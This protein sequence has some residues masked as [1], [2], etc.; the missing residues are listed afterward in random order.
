MTE[1]LVVD[2]GPRQRNIEGYLYL[3]LPPT[4]GALCWHYLGDGLWQIPAILLAFIVMSVV[5][6]AIAVRLG[7]ELVT[8]IER[9]RRML[10]RLGAQSLPSMLFWMFLFYLLLFLGLYAPMIK[11]PLSWEE[12]GVVLGLI[13][14]GAT[15]CTGICGFYMRGQIAASGRDAQ[16]ATS[17]RAPWLWLAKN[18]PFTFIGV[19]GIAIGYVI[20]SRFS[21]T[22]ALLVLMAGAFGG[23]IVQTIAKSWLTKDA[24]ILW[25][26]FSFGAAVAA[27]ASLYGIYFAAFVG[28][29]ELLFAHVS[30]RTAGGIVLF[31]LGGFLGGIL[32]AVVA[33]ALAHFNTV[34]A[35]S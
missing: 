5:G 18:L 25:H 4:I 30:G 7:G 15:V 34:K 20:G 24:P 3:I 29:S 33:W 31:A 12:G 14:S 10:E 11:L 21:D 26:D 35:R 27:G 16:I 32:F 28:C 22:T 1:R 8:P 9:R 6:N 17:P 2:K 23:L 13:F 19:A